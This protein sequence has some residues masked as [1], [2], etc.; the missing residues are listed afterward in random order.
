M[1][2]VPVPLRWLLAESLRIAAILLLAFLVGVLIEESIGAF[3][4]ELL[5]GIRDELAAVVQYTGIVTAI[6]YAVVRGT[7]VD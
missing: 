5:Y 3:G 1:K 7:A 2:H 4:L 6:L